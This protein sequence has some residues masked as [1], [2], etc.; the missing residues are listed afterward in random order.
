V[1]PFTGFQLQGFNVE[2]S[3]ITDFMGF[4]ALAYH[5]GTVTGSDGVT[6]NL[7]ADIR[8]M[9]GEYIGEDGRRHEGTFAEMWIDLFTPGSGAQQVHDYNGGIPPSGL[10]WTVELPR[11][12]F[13]VSRRERQ[14]RLKVRDLAMI[15]TFQLFGP[16]DTPAVLDITMEWNALDDPVNLG[17]GNTVPPTDSAAF[18]GSF[19]RARSTAHFSAR[20]LGFSFRSDPGVSSDL[21]YAEI[22]RESN[23]VFLS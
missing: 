12:S 3:T 8:V 10:F 15:D 1:L 21:G 9:E 13:S 11:E 23:G 6:Y 19:A 16:R 2:P 22:G 17:S 14:A 18:L 20:Q 5:A 7:E 4:T